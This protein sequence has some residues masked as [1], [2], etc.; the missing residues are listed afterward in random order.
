MVIKSR[1][2]IVDQED[3]AGNEEPFCKAAFFNANE[4]F[5]M[6]ELATSCRP[7]CTERH[8]KKKAIVFAL[9]NIM[10]VRE[11]AMSKREVTVTGEGLQES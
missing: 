9:N 10:I 7:P 3:A 5:G 8:F 6:A 1:H 4:L 2:R 11:G